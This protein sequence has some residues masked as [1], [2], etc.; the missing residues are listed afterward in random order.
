ME[1][2]ASR[3]GLT[4]GPHWGLLERDDQNK[5][6]SRQRLHCFHLCP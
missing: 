3:T 6:G 2:E 4:V 5:V 1:L